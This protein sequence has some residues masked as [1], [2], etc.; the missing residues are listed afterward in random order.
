MESKHY[1]QCLFWGM[2]LLLGACQDTTKTVD[3]PT[4]LSKNQLQAFNLNLQGDTTIV[5]NN[6]ALLIIPQCAFLLNGEIIDQQAIKIEFAELYQPA[7]FV[8]SNLQTITDKNE[9]LE[10][11]GMFH[12]Q[13]KN[14]DG[15][16]LKINPTC[17]PLLR[18]GT[19]DIKPNLEVYDGKMVNGEVLWTQPKSL[20]KWL[21][22]IPL[23]QLKFYANPDKEAPSKWQSFLFQPAKGRFIQQE[24]VPMYCGLKNKLVDSLYNPIF[25]NTLIATL[26][27]SMRMRCIHQTC[28]EKVLLIYLNNLDKNLYEIDELV[29]TYLTEKNDP[30]AGNFRCFAQQKLTKVP[31]A[32][33]VPKAYIEGIQRSIRF[34]PKSLITHSFRISNMGWHNIDALHRLPN[35]FEAKE[36]FELITNEIKIDRTVVY[37]ITKTSNTTIKLVFNKA[38]SHYEF[39]AYLRATSE[40]EMVIYAIGTNKFENYACIQEVEL[41]KHP[42]YALTLTPTNEEEIAVVLAKYGQPKPQNTF[43]FGDSECCH[44]DYNYEQ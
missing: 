44:Y 5:T 38:K 29:A 3:F 23:Q 27:F 24:D 14:A 2:L 35:T 34:S 22:P 40:K 9:L 25:E 43:K 18:F 37:C 7:D 33:E 17:A 10:S 32:N 30:N 26:E 42:T 36:T 20:E 16:L 28:S 8:A 31:K 4:T 21:S 39:P 1:P 19:K 13:A 11:A 15:Q 12:I 6:N 41:G